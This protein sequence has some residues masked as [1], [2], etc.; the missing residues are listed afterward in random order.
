[1]VH[2]SLHSSQ[3]RV[4]LCFNNRWI[5]SGCEVLGSD[6]QQQALDLLLFAV[7]KKTIP[8]S[9][10]GIQFLA[11]IWLPAPGRSVLGF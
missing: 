7:M 5:K 1:M 11:V 2:F 10:L 6:F 4:S 9:L 8:Q 3:V